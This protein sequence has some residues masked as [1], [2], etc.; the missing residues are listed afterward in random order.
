MV[1]ATE[2]QVFIG[3]YHDPNNTNLYLSE[4]MGL[5]YSLSLERIISP[6]ESEWRDGY[7]TFDVYVMEGIKGTYFA[8]KKVPY[9]SNGYTVISFDK[10]GKWD[11]V[12]PPPAGANESPCTSVSGD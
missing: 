10:G 6:P 2:G 4:E 12:S 11:P 5:N 8:N 3:V 7:P 9:S 1:D